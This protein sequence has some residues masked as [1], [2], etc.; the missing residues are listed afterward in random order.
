MV[1]APVISQL[2]RRDRADVARLFLIAI[3]IIV[4]Q[5]FGLY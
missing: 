2:S 1:I 5:Y 4:Q 3:M